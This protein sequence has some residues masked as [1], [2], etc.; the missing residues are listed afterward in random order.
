MN[1]L[2]QN[3]TFEKQ[4]FTTAPPAGDEFEHCTFINCD[5]SGA[6]L[7]GAVFDQCR[8]T[9]SNLSLAKLKKAVLRDVQFSGCKMLGL[10]FED[11]N[12]FR[13]SF[14]LSGCIVNHSSF[15]GTKM[16]KVQF[17]DTE[18][19]ETDFTDCDLT[20]AVLSNCDL[21]GALFDNTNLEKANLSTALNYSIDPEKN[22][23]KKAKFSL[24]GIPGL[25]YKYGIEIEG[26]N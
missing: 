16:K 25:L 11:C 14:S 23:I 17:A 4:D 20:G 19:R 24:T 1:Q 26:Y 22:R 13:L 2:Y 5:F 10:H 6:D 15:Y 7:S 3:Q 21:T 8:F 9:D 18:L 12:E